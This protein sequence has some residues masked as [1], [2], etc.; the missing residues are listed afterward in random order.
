MPF[1]ISDAVANNIP[2]MLQLMHCHADGVY[3]LNADLR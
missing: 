3:A 2:F 1:L